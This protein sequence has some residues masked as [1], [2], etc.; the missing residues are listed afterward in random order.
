MLVNDLNNAIFLHCQ[1]L[2]DNAGFLEAYIGTMFKVSGTIQALMRLHM[3]RAHNCS[4]QPEVWVRTWSS[5]SP[6]WGDQ[7]PLPVQ[8]SQ[9]WVGNAVGPMTDPWGYAQG[10]SNLVIC[11]KCT[12]SL[13]S[14]LSKIVNGKEVTS[15]AQQKKGYGTMNSSNR[16]HSRPTRK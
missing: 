5:W 9:R 16:L 13:T 2:F 11:F 8:L 15:H 6:E 10:E 14:A 7:L 12:D 1:W 4:L 3:K